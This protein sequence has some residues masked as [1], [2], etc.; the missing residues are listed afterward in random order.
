MYVHKLTD[1]TGSGGS[2]I[3]MDTNGVII[4][5]MSALQKYYPVGLELVDVKLRR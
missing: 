2:V 4:C 5:T 3:V 1:I